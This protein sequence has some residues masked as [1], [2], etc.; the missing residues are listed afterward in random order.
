MKAINNSSDHILAFGACFSPKAD[1][2]LVCIQDANGSGENSSYNTH[3][4]NIQNKPR[5]VTGASFIVFNGAL[6]SSSGL[7]A[8]SSIVEDGLMIQIPAENMEKIRDS[9]K[10]MKNYTIQCGCVNAESDETVNIIWGESDVN[11]N[12]GVESVIDKQSLSSV[13]SI[14][15]HNGKDYTSN[16]GNYFIRW[17]EVFI[18]QNSEENSKNQ[19]TINI[20]KISESIA[21]AVCQALIK[22][23]DLLSSNNFHKIGIRATLNVDNVCICYYIV[24]VYVC[25]FFLKV[26][27]CAGS[28][29]M[30]LPPI[31]MKSLDNELV[32]VLHRIT[33]NNLGEST[34]ILELIF[35]ILNI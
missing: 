17:T 23:L 33:A 25:F 12:V 15:V 29:N 14:R 32:P 10:N 13:P 28:N 27:Y 2:H 9:L 7:T 31:Y 26:S 30:K 35:R 6:K 20:S 11:F 19:D 34:V 21:K 4:I 8:K 16:T 22:Y 3:A 24:Y 1:S 5:K 18:I